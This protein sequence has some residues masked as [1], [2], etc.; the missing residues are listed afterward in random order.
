ML[1]NIAATAACITL[2]SVTAAQESHAQA[3]QQGNQSGRADQSRGSQGLEE[4]VVTATKRDTALVE[5]PLAVTVFTMDDIAQKNITRPADFISMTPNVH[6]TDAIRPGSNDVSMRGVQGN[7]GLTQPVAVVIDGV[8]SANPRGLDRE[9]IAIQQI[10]VVRG[11]QS[12][13]YGRNANAGAII[14]NTVR[15]SDDLF[16]KVSVGAG[17][18]GSLKGQAM[19]S[20]PIVDGS[21]Y[22]RLALSG[23]RRDGYW[24]N[25]T[26][27]EP[28]DEYHEYVADARVVYDATER[29]SVDLRARVSELQQ[30]A[31]LWTMQ[32]PAV[33]PFDV[34]NYF[35]PFQMNNK[36]AGYQDRGDFALKVGYEMPFA[37]F[38]AIGAYSTYHLDEDADGGLIL[39]QPGGAGGA[40]LAFLPGGPQAI[41]GANPPLLPGFSYSL[42]DGNGYIVNEQNDKTVELRL[43]SPSEQRL[44]WMAGVY[45]ADSDAENYNSTRVD[46]GQGVI[47]SRYAPELFDINGS[48]PIRVL[49]ADDFSNEAHAAFGQLQYDFTDRL[50][51]SAALRWDEENKRTVNTVP[52]G[53]SPV[54]GLPWTNPI[55]APS[56]QVREKDYS[57]VQPQVSLRYKVSSDLAFYTSYGEGFRSGGFNAAG[58]AQDFGYPEDYPSETSHAYE[59]GMKSQWLDRR[60]LLNLALFYTDIDNAQAFVYFATPRSATINITLDKVRAQGVEVEAAFRVTDYLSIAN[61]FGITDAQTEADKLPAVIGKKVPQMPEYTNSLSVDY[62]RPLFGDL[63]LAGNISWSLEGPMWFD[64]YNTPYAERDPLSLINARIAVGADRDDGGGWEFALWGK[65]IR[66]EWYNQYAAPAGPVMNVYRGLPRTYGASLTYRF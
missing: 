36:S 58:A 4:V 64:V 26:L 27:G 11:P 61:N 48:N 53:N 19:V 57:A 31:E 9:L 18:G 42:D 25:K 44:R 29:L 65:N 14:I 39:S 8:A 15:P 32:V 33:H 41:L 43:A 28:Q 24:D 46:K 59:V 6:L 45:Y 56:G 17:N 1:S 13:V 37:T 2:I 38:T 12:A 20:G 3:A 47:R 10:E 52:L 66:N 7:F 35:P 55:L 40:P 51:G 54:S 63:N 34:N 21:V 50:E 30:G 60:I 62:N 22:G 49:R 5:V 16:G 23:E